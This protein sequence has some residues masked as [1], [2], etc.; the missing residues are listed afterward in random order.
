M[1]DEIAEKVFYDERLAPSEK[2]VALAMATAEA[3]SATEFL[4]PSSLGEIIGATGQSRRTV[5]NALLGLEKA[6]VIRRPYATPED[7]RAVVMK[8]GHV[9]CGFG[10]YGCEWCG[11]KTWAIHEHHYPLSRQE[12]GTSVVRIC[13][14][15]HAEY[16]ALERGWVIS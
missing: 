15:C 10:P 14:S 3:E 9:P 5:Y 11:A 2:L 4:L 12:G 7:I 6:G 13:G 16:H 8:K 1:Y